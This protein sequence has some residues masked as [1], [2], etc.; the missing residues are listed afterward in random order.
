MTKQKF[1]LIVEA[2]ES[3]TGHAVKQIMLSIK[4]GGITTKEVKCTVLLH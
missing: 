4:D 3:A 2:K 1:L